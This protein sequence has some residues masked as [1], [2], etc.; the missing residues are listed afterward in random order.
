MDALITIEGTVEDIIFTNEANGYTV[1]DVKNSKDMVTAVGIMPFLSIG[2]SVKIVGR[3][4]EHP[5]YGEQFKVE[6]Y[7]KLL[8][9]TSEAI[10][11]YLASGVLKGIGPATAAKIV[12]KFGEDTL[13]IIGFNP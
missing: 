7:E 2:E 8:P 6:Y 3:W 5:D 10:E 13:N 11:K 12:K 9:K 1:C 4:I